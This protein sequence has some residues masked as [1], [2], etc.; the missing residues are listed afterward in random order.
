MMK[1]ARLTLPHGSRT[2]RAVAFLREN[3]VA[4]KVSL[5]SGSFGRKTC[6]RGRRG[7]LRKS[8]A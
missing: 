4:I 8:V 1:A 2:K 7:R 3:L 6:Q 5:L